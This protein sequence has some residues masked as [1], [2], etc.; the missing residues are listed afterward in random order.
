MSIFPLEQMI[1]IPYTESRKHVFTSVK[2]R[3]VLWNLSR[4]ADGFHFREKNVRETRSSS[5]N[6]SLALARF[7]FPLASRMRTRNRFRTVNSSYV[8]IY[9][10]FV[11]IFRGN[12]RQFRVSISVTLFPRLNWIHE[13]TSVL[14]TTNNPLFGSVLPRFYL[15]YWCC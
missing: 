10:E 9:P 8:C 7:Y 13:N 1:L 12:I 6:R 5:G 14:S 4:L 11:A 2:S 3:T 15:Y